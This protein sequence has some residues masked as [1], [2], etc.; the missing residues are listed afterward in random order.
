MENTWIF[1][2]KDLLKL[3]FKL[4]HLPGKEV[5]HGCHWVID[6]AVT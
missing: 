4:N 3:F 2:C 1:K 6:K 5:E